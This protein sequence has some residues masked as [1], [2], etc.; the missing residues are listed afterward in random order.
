MMSCA[1][2]TELVTTYLERRMPL[3]QRL[4]FRAHLLL[5]PHCRRYLAQIR[6]TVA[7]TGRLPTEPIPPEV[8][9]DLVKALLAARAAAARDDEG[10]EPE[11][12]R[13]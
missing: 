4:S 8:K 12:P 13:G 2:V 1:E 10:E 7:L 5:C 3:R 6:A 9:D 11:R